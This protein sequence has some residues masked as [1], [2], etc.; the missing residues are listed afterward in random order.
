MGNILSSAAS[1]RSKAVKNRLKS[2]VVAEQ[3]QAEMVKDLDGL[4]TLIELFDKALRASDNQGIADIVSEIIKRRGVPGFLTGFEKTLFNVFSVVAPLIPNFTVPFFIE[5]LQSRA[6][7]VV[8]LGEDYKSKIKGTSNIEFNLNQLGEMILGEAE[9]EQKTVE[10]VALLEDPSVSCISVKVSNLYSQ[11]NPLAFAHS[12]KV[13]K[14]RLRPRIR[15]AIANKPPEEAS[16]T[17]KM[18]N[19]YMEEYLHLDITLQVFKEILMEPEFMN[20]EM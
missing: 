6:S 19:L 5:E 15:A 14:D 7:S 17:H 9:A 8:A 12:V 13:I 11:I 18:I 16:R 10:D 4:H 3:K 2:E 20:Y 1:L